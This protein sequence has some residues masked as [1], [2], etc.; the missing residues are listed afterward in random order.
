M[1]FDVD[2]SKEAE[3]KWLQLPELKKIKM[4]LLLRD[5]AEKYIEVESNEIEKRKSRHDFSRFIKPE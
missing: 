5:V 2:L 4:A 3:E 1:N